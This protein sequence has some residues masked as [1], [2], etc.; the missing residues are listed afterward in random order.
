MANNRGP[1]LGSSSSSSSTRSPPEVT[2]VAEAGDLILAVTFENSKATVRAARKA[3]ALKASLARADKD[4]QPA[5]PPTAKAR[6]RVPFRVQASVLRRQ[7]K[8]FDKLLGDSHFKEAK[9]VAEALA[10]L[11]LRNVKPADADPAELPWVEITD[12]DEATLYAHRELVFA[13]LLRILHGQPV[14]AGTSSVA[15]TTTAATK[16]T[17]QYVTT[18]AVLADRFDCTAPVSSYV[19]ASLKFRWPATSRKMP[20]GSGRGGDEGPGLSRA[21]EDVLRQKILVGWLLNQPPIVRTGTRELIMSGSSRWSS[22]AP[23]DESEQGG[24]QEATWWYLPEGLEEELQYRRQCVLNTIASIQQH[25]LSLYSSRNAP[26]QC[27]LG[28]DSSAACDSYQLGEMIRF[29]ANKSLLFL[30]DFSPGSLDRIADTSQVTVDSLLATLRQCPSYQIDKNHNN[31]GLRT[32]LLPI[33]DFVQGLLSSNAV[34]V[35]RQAWKTD[36]AGTASGGSSSNK[37]FRFT[38][39]MAG[40]QRLRF[41]GNLGAD[42]FARQVFLASSW[43][44]TADDDASAAWSNPGKM[45]RV[46]L[47]FK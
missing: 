14:V 34:P 26:R 6:S 27:K 1:L 4:R 9:D 41:E 42:R 19:N 11:S 22:F 40:D 31:C 2:A 16:I 17:P 21:A 7:S 15:A 3:Q 44:W 8:Y 38:R 24:K 46:P 20:P 18:L 29:L 32:R 35:S 39:T 12:D 45:G 23:E 28:Y 25:F 30:V 10:A 33:L 43:D 47:S 36:R 37:P 5:L 13:D